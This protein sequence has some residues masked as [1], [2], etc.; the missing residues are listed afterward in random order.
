MATRYD[1]GS[2]APVA[3]YRRRLCSPVGADGRGSR[4]G[5]T[6]GPRVAGLAAAAAFVAWFALTGGLAASGFLDK[7]APPRL[8]L[9]LGTVLAVLLWAS[10][11]DWTARLENLPLSLLVGFQ[12][13][14][15]IVELL[16]HKAVVEG[17]AAPTHTWTATNLGIRPGAT[18]LLPTPFAQRIPREWLQTWNVSS[19]LILAITVV[20][21]LLAMSTPFQQIDGNPPNEWVAT[22][23]FVWLPAVLVLCAWLGDVVLFRRLLRTS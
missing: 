13:F 16:I 3:H 9:A 23:P 20:T 15:I 5:L 14:R 11:A 12:S 2:P 8:T 6:P 18:A 4:S 21:A 1:S 17:V 7:W 19:A 22:L 10:R